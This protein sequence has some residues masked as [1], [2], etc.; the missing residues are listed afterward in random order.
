VNER[1]TARQFLTNRKTVIDLLLEPESR[2]EA[3]LQEAIIPE[4]TVPGVSLL[5]S[6]LQ[7]ATAENYLRASPVASPLGYLRRRI[8]SLLKQYD[9]YPH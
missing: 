2:A 9:L 7:L 8:R 5:P 1:K 4:T 3:V 6:N